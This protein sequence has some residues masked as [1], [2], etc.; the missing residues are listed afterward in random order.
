MKIK[1]I[2]V[3]LDQALYPRQEI[4]SANLHDILEAR[5]AGIMLPPITVERRTLRL[6]DGW[7]RVNAELKLSGDDVE[8]EAVAKAYENDA[9]LFLD[10]VRLNAGHGQKL[11][12]FDQARC[13]SRSAE[14][15]IA[16]D[17]LTAALGITASQYSKME[18]HKFA[19]R[20]K[21]PIPIKRTVS[22]LA[23]EELTAAQAQAA[24]ATGGL[25]Q[26]VY[27]NQVINL[28]EGNILNTE[29]GRLMERLGILGNL[30]DAVCM[31]QDGVATGS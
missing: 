7:H 13:M 21:K 8:I 12:H 31:Q 22:H 25:A 2:D 26:L 11:S 5:Q 10:A 23:G 19:T 6:V 15:K 29:S 20:G 14:L 9:E 4:S 16:P 28:I 3:V 18:L 1:A 17:R 30:I 27:V 24:D